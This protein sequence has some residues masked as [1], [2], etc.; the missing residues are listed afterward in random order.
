MRKLIALES[1]CRRCEKDLGVSYVDPEFRYSHVDKR[2]GDK[3]TETRHVKILCRECRARV[4][5][6]I[7]DTTQRT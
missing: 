5:P 2:D 6:Y 4:A 7:V 3:V 1:E